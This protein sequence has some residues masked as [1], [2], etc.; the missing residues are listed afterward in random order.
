MPRRPE[1]IGVV[2]AEALQA[3]RA[4][5]QQRGVT[6]RSRVHP[7]DALRQV[8]ADRRRLVQVFGK[9]LENA[10]QH[11]RAGTEVT[12]TGSHRDQDRPD[13][14]SLA[15]EDQGPGFRPEDLPR[16][17][18]PFFTRRAGGTGLGLSIVLRTIEDHGGTVAVTNRSGGGAAVEVRLPLLPAVE[19]H[20]A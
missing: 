16:V 18:E 9:L 17:F 4:M 1:A 8:H 12:V 7:D 11:T 10:I 3:S 13:D 19:G 14:F 20:G 5:A 6:L 15:V 2:L